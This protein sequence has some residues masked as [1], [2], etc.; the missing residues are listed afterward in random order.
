MNPPFGARNKGADMIFL[1]AAIKMARTSVYSLH[2]TATRQHVLRKSKEWGM[3]G[4]VLAEL[5][6]DIP[7][8]YKFHKSTSKDI[9]VDF[10]RFVRHPIS[11]NTGE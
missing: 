5:R 1:Y 7:Q 8:M 4:E 9:E 10:I 11:N 2:K 3:E 6:F